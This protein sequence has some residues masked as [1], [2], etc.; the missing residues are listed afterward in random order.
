MPIAPIHREAVARIIDRHGAERLDIA[1]MMVRQ[2]IS[3]ESCRVAAAQAL[4]NAVN[5]ILA[6]PSASDEG[7]AFQSRAGKWVVAC[8]GASCRS[9]SCPMRM[10]D[11]CSCGIEA[12]HRHEMFTAPNGDIRLAVVYQSDVHPRAEVRDAETGEMIFPATK[13]RTD[14]AL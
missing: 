6:L 13:T 5:A 1:S 12:P 8:F 10:S 2:D 9:S 4:H 14:D 7:E 11:A 3:L